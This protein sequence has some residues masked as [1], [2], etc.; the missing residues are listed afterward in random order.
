[1]QPEHLA[2]RTTPTFADAVHVSLDM[3]TMRSEICC[4]VKA[5]DA[6]CPWS[7]DA[8][9]RVDGPQAQ[10]RNELDALHAR[11]RKI[12][13]EDC[14]WPDYDT[15]PPPGIGMKVCGPKVSVQHLYRTQL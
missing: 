3:S 13:A 15:G 2:T 6:R 10:D 14:S 11:D 1:M 9:G 8:G 7:K 5:K 4:F 12:I